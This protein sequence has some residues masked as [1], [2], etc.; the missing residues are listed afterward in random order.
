MPVHRV[1]SVLRR[2]L[3][4]AAI[5]CA[6]GAIM[7]I[8]IVLIGWFPGAM[9]TYSANPDF[10]DPRASLLAWCIAWAT[11]CGSAGFVVGVIVGSLRATASR[12]D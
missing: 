1:L 6:A 10:I 7:G 9:A 8:L 12:S 11:V 5:A 3:T 4:C 2:I